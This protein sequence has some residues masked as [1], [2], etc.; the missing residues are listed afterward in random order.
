MRQPSAFTYD[1]AIRYRADEQ[2]LSGIPVVVVVVVIFDVAPL[3]LR[4]LHDKIP[5]RKRDIQI[6]SAVHSTG[7]RGA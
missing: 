2:A 5:L 4:L 7:E 3:W 6:R 1:Y